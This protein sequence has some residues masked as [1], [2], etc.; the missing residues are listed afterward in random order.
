MSVSRRETRRGREGS[1]GFGWRARERAR[2]VAMVDFPTPPLALETAIV[3]F[4][5][6]IGLEVGTLRDMR[7]ERFGEGGLERGRPWEEV[8]LACIFH[9]AI[10][11]IDYLR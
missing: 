2:L 1:V 6:G 5:L 7:E 4:T 8:W 11:W 9:S 10:G 3:F